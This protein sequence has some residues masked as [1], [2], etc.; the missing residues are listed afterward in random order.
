L[1][2]LERQ[3]PLLEHENIAKTCFLRIPAAKNAFVEGDQRLAGRLSQRGWALVERST[4]KNVGLG[5]L[6]SWAVM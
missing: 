2:I 3:D 1:A 5:S 6:N 4:A